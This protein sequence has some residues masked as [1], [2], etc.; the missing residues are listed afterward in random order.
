MYVCVCVCKCVCVCVCVCVRVCLQEYKGEAY[1]LQIELERLNHA[2]GL[3][4][5]KVT[6]EADRSAIQE[7]MAELKMLWDNLDEK[8]I[9][10]QVREGDRPPPAPRVTE[11][12]PLYCFVVNTIM[13]LTGQRSG[14]Q[15]IKCIRSHRIFFLNN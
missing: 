8:I 10:R 4:L 15:L 13:S 11:H 12:I 14:G 9:N 3:L 5:K 7:P 1:Q 2:A 6:D